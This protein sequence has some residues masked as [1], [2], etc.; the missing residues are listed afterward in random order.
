MLATLELEDVEEAR[1]EAFAFG[2]KEKEKEESGRLLD[3]V[4]WRRAGNAVGRRCVRCRCRC[5]VGAAR[6]DDPLDG[7]LGLD[8]GISTS[9]AATGTYTRALSDR[10]RGRERCMPADKHPM[11]HAHTDSTPAPPSRSPHPNPARPK[12][13]LSDPADPRRALLSEHTMRFGRASTA[14]RPAVP[15]RPCTCHKRD[16]D[17]HMPIQIPGGEGLVRLEG[18]GASFAKSA[19]CRRTGGSGVDECG[20]GYEW[21]VG[22]SDGVLRTGVGGWAV[23][24]DSGRIIMWRLSG[25]RVQGPAT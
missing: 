23:M 11:P 18:D 19:H 1:G 25:R 5:G 2:I 12:A 21:A 13:P 16:L 20:R 7:V 14:A 15:I 10:S 3:H 24:L 8:R 9:S 22:G 17:I 6:H 4:L